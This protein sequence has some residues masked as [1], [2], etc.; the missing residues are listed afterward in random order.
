MVQKGTHRT[1]KIAISS[2]RV[3]PGVYEALKILSKIQKRSMGE[4]V[5]DVLNQTEPMIRAVAKA[6]QEAQQQKVL[7]FDKFLQMTMEKLKKEVTE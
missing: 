3:E 1:Q 7:N 2:I 6:V 5:A 4:L